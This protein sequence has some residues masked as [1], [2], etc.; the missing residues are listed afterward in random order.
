VLISKA[1]TFTSGRK[2]EA[3]NLLGIGR[4][5]IARKISE[6]GLSFDKK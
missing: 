5:T 4:N 3:A 2:I 6:L 1:L